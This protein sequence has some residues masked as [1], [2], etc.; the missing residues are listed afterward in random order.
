MELPAAGEHVFAV[1]SIEK[2]RSR[3][4]RI[5][6]LVKWRGWSP[7][8]NTWEPEENILDPRLLDAFQDRERQEQL[9]GYRKRGPKPKHLLVQVPSFARRSNILA[10][11]CEEES[12]QKS[13]S[14]QMQYQLNGKKH[15]PYQPLSQDLFIFS[16]II[17]KIFVG[18]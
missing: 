9:M 15:H 5:E 16:H 4:G 12:Q 14:I 3:K 10:D 11:I 6:Y 13:N 1:E 18:L 8:Y 17:F 7:K 2:K